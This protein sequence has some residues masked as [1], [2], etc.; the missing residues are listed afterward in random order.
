MSAAARETA[1]RRRRRLRERRAGRE[2]LPPVTSYLLA[3]GGEQLAP[4]VVYVPHRDP[5]A[6]Y[7]WGH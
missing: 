1:R 5:F 2:I 6:S 7:P 3:Q 4:G